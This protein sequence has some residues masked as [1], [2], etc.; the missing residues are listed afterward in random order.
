MLN[1]SWDNET[2]SIHGVAPRPGYVVNVRPE[3]D[4]S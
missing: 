4:M 1:S 2:V 3:P